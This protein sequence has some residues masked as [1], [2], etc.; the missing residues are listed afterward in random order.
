MT[1]DK[2]A[3]IRRRE[4]YDRQACYTEGQSQGPVPMSILVEEL[5]R[6]ILSESHGVAGAM[7]VQL[8]EGVSKKD[9]FAKVP[10]KSGGEK[11]LACHFCLCYGVPI[12][13]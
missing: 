8:A 4:R 2:D 6:L 10:Q 1:N 11:E 13:D 3:G 9:F 12:A 5:R 7:M